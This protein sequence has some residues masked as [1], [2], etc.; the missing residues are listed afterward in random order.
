[1]EILIPILAV[2]AIGLICGVGLSI[3]SHVMAVKEDERFPLVRECLP[4]ANCGACGYTGCDGYAKALLEPGTKTNLCVPGADAVAKQIAEVLGVEAEDVVEQVAVVKCKG[5]CEATKKKH[6]YQGIKTCA[7]AKLFYGGTGACSFGCLGFGDCA[8]VCPQN[9]ISYDMGIAKIDPKKCVGCGLCKKTCPQGIITLIDDVEL[10]LVT[11]SNTNKG[12]DTR[13]ACTNGCIGCMKCQKNCPMEAVHIENN[14]AVIDYKVCVGCGVC[15]K[16]CPTG[17][18]QIA[19]LLG[20][21][22]Q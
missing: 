3:A 16:E 13:K 2:T 14:L 6:D 1:M 22:K 19:S 12:A 10:A 7:A 21:H 11:C 17:A 20:A 18:I 4:G 8:K 5:N 9:A 15:A